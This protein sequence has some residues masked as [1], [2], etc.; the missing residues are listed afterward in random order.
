[1]LT[2]PLVF[3]MPDLRGRCQGGV[4]LS[5]E[6][7]FKIKGTLR[8]YL[9]EHVRFTDIEIAHV[10]PEQFFEGISQQIAASLVYIEEMAS[11]IEPE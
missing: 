6:N 8:S 9:T 10:H 1:M 5:P 4:V 11:V 3:I 7:R 2:V